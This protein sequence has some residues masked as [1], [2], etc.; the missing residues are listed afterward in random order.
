MDDIGGMKQQ[1]LKQRR[2]TKK[3]NECTQY[4]QTQL[5]VTGTEMSWL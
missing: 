2:G 4:T 5:Q 3:R 1:K